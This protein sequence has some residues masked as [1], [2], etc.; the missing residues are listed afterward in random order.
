MLGVKGAF[1]LPILVKG[2]NRLVKVTEAA[3][4]EIKREVNDVIEEGKKPLIRLSM[5]IG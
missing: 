3:L 2:G 4:E 5:G 1:C